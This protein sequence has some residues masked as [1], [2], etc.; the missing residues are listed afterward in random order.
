[1]ISLALKITPVVGSVANVGYRQK[2]PSR[3][4]L[5]ALVYTSVLRMHACSHCV[6]SPINKFSPPLNGELW[7]HFICFLFFCQVLSSVEVKKTTK[8]KLEPI[9]IR[10]T[11][12][13]WIGTVAWFSN[14]SMEHSP[15]LVMWPLNLAIKP[16]MSLREGWMLVC[17]LTSD[18]CE[19]KKLSL[20]VLIAQSL[21]SP[22]IADKLK[23]TLD[24]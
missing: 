21:S 12:H 22:L 9:Q 2:T 17:E 20:H 11:I 19:K 5:A 16:K 13:L 18:L 4:P 3:L 24:I 10:N 23:R 1:M 8:R 15:R 6:K 7:R 14:R